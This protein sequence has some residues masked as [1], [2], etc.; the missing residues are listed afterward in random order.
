MKVSE[1]KHYCLIKSLSRLVDS[2]LSKHE[3]EQHICR[4]CL[5]PFNSE[6]SLNKHK[7]Y[8]DSHAAVK[9]VMPGEGSILKFKN[10]VRSMRVPFVV[11]ADFESFTQRLDTVQPNPE[12]SFT[13]QYQKHTPSGFCY[14]IKALDDSVYKSRPVLYTKQS[15]DEDVAQI[16]VDRL[17]KDI[18]KI[19]KKCGRAK[20]V[21]TPEEQQ[22]FERATTCWICEDELVK[23]PT[24]RGY[25][26]LKP[27][28]DHCHYTGK[29]RGPAH[30][31]CN[32][33]YRKPKFTPVIFHNLSGY[34]SHLFVKKLGKTEGNIK[35][36]PN[37]E[38]KYISFSK[39]IVVGYYTDQNQ[40]S[41][42]HYARDKVP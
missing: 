18:T 13:K 36:I 1:R 35:C 20:M 15:E 27:V 40:S 8:C 25:G 31:K 24:Q 22:A 38:E 37:N 39:Q 19:Y 21:I 29:Y 42:E 11:Y 16:F 17:E 5:N 6:D 32:L 30:N 33:K 9:V 3:H 12:N 34:D 14:Y 4:R 2:Q 28:R 7:E 23:D 26:K 41:T 10:F